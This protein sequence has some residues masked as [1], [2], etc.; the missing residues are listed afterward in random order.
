[1]APRKT[2]LDALSDR[3]K[4]ILILIAQGYQQKEIAGLLGIEPST[5]R[6]HTEEVRQKLNVSSTRAAAR[7]YATSLGVVPPRHFNGGEESRVSPPPSAAPVSGHEH[8]VPHHERTHPDHPQERS[9]GR[10]PDLNTSGEASEYLS[11]P[12]HHL[13]GQG[14]TR[15]GSRHHLADVRDDRVRRY[16]AVTGW[17]RSLNL[18]QWAGLTLLTTLAVILL[19]GSAVIVLLGIFQAITQI[20]G[21]TG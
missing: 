12:G 20:S 10:H 6:G 2:G 4:E 14:D 7:L 21:Q 1:M 8:N 5:I 16:L 11:D 9:G 19:T 15:G 13:P 18:I 3:Q 17:L